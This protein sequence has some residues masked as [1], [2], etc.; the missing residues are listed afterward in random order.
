M[1]IAR[2][3]IPPLVLPREE[4]DVPGLGSVWVQGLDMPGLLHFTATRRRAQEPREGETE[5]EAAERAGAE[6]VPVLLER[7]VLAADE[8]PVYTTAQWSIW[9]VRNG[10]AALDLF[11]HALRLSGQDA[12]PGNS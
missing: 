10:T 7:C 8:L 4:V 11:Q 3:Q 9:M 12:G 2:D 5:Q 1:P 6:L